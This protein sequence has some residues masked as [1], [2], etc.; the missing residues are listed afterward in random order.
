VLCASSAGVFLF[1]VASSSN[2]TAGCAGKHS[3]KSIV[4]EYRN[5]VD[6]AATIK[7]FSYDVDLT[8][9]RQHCEST[10]ETKKKIHKN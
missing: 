10:A 8:L 6:L 3:Q 7:M 2:G 9:N 1:D 4:G 5:D